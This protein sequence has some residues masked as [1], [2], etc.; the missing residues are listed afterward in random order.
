MVEDDQLANMKLGTIVFNKGKNSVGV[1]FFGDKVVLKQQ[2]NS[3]TLNTAEVE[4]I[5]LECNHFKNKKKLAESLKEDEKEG[6]K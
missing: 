4:M 2:G 6:L 5:N 1:K 3:I